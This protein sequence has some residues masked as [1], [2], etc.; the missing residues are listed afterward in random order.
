[1]SQPE[2]Q[3]EQP[4]ERQSDLDTG[5][6]ALPERLTPIRPV[7]AIAICASG[8]LLPGV[9][10]VLLGR[11]IRGLIFLISVMTMFVL[12]IAMDGKLY[13]LA[14]EQPLHVFALIADLGVGLPYLFARQFGWGVGD[15]AKTTYDYGTTYLWVSGLLNYLIM[16]DAFDIS[17]GRKR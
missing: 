4:P 2:K 5:N 14:F 8:W 3:L 16:L 9:S 10:H 6:A 1:M 13:D 17:R 7:V 15:L 11:W 12:G